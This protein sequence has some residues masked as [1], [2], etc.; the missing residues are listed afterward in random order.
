LDR[1]G[2]N[3]RNKGKSLNK[4][5]FVALDV[6]TDADAL[7]IA[8]L[9][10]PYVGGF[11]VGPRL[12]VRY[13]EKLLSQ[14][15][16][17]APLFIDNKYFDIPSTMEGAIRAS[18]DMG[19]SYTTIHAQ[20]G[21]EAMSQLAKVEKELN[22]TRPFKILAVTILTSFQSETLPSILKSMPIP[23]M[24]EELARLTVESGLSGLVCSPEEVANLRQKFPNTFLLVPGIRMAGHDLSDQK[25]VSDPATALA[26]GASA[27][28]VGR[29]ICRA[30]NPA[31]AAKL[32]SDVIQNSR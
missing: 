12:I 23:D 9:T 21:S 13:G 24:V 8:E 1:K 17:K 20:A 11:K 19:A 5:L 30:D 15:Q 3:G 2:K 7:R 22:E 27:L 6:D 14:L 32:Y 16:K 10:A 28:V 26:S 29:P 18:F 4:P 31:Q 25:R